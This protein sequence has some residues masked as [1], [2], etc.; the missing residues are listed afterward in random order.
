LNKLF[1]TLF[2]ASLKGDELRTTKVSVIVLNPEAPDPAPPPRIRQ[3]RWSYVKLDSPQELSIGVLSKLSQATDPRSSSLAIW[4]RGQH[5]YV[6]GLIDQQNGFYDFINYESQSGPE[7]PGI[8][9]AIVS[10]PGWLTIYHEYERLAELRV[11]TISIRQPDVLWRGP[12]YDQLEPGISRYIK[13]VAKLLSR[14]DDFAITPGHRSTLASFWL[15]A[16]SRLMI[17]TK[18]FRHGAGFLFAKGQKDLNVKHSINYRR[19]RSALDGIGYFEASMYQQEEAITALEKKADQ[20]PMGLYYDRILSED[21]LQDS[22]SELDSGIWFVSLLSRI[23]G[24][25]LLD[26]DMSVLGFGVEI[27]TTAAPT[28]I[29]RATDAV[30]SKRRTHKVDYQHF[31]TRP[32]SMM[33]YCASHP[34]SIGFVISQDGDVRAITS[35]RGR[36]LL[37]DDIKLQLDFRSSHSA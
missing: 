20:L 8:F 24:A 9:Q 2:F 1:E 4:F 19:I 36:V 17:R 18:A 12:V 7:R 21:D 33:R 16:L 31:G 34:G 13:R 15:Q 3:D 35:D 37:W 32:R 10:S 28:F 27:L 29:Y 22:R 11:S 26:F 25:V 30:G 23:D 5:P 6:W 14:H